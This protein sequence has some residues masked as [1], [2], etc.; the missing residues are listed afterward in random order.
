MAATMLPGLVVAVLLVGAVL[1]A[2]LPVRPRAVALLG[3]ATGVISGALLLW[4]A[5]SVWTGGPVAATWLDRLPLALPSAVSVRVDALSAIFLVLLAVVSAAVLLFAQGYLDGRPAGPTRR[6]YGLF[7]L[8]V[9]AMA[10]VVMAADWVLFLFA[11]EI[12]TLASYFLVIWDW[13]E[14]R[15]ARSAWVYL[16]TTHVASSG[17]LIAMCSLSVIAGDFSFAATAAALTG[18]FARL[19]AFAHLL[20][21]CFVLGF[22]TKA[23]VWPFSFWLPEAYRSAPMPATAVYSGLMAKMGIYGLVR[24]L[25]GMLPAGGQP[26]LIWGLIV[27]T[28][29]TAS[30]LV[31]NIRSLSEL[32]AKRLVAQSSIGQIG[33]IVLGVGMAAALSGR[34]PLLAAVAFAGA[35]YHLINHATFKPLLFLTVG[36]VEHYS[37][38]QDLK[39][40]GGL[41]GPL[42]LTAGLTLLGALA[43]AG[44]PPLNGFASKWLL[45]RA[46]VFGGI[47][48]PALAVYGVIA[49][50]ISTV[51]L[52]AYL[53][54][55]GTVFLG[56]E[57]EYPDGRREPESRAMAASLAILGA[58]CVALGLFP[59]PVVQ[60][61]LVALAGAPDAALF[62]A[63]AVTGA[64]V[65]GTALGGAGYQPLMVVLALLLCALLVWLIR[66]L[67]TQPVRLTEPWFGGEWLPASEARYGAEH[68]YKPFLAH[69]AALLRPWWQPTFHAPP[70]LEQAIDADR[71][72][73]RPIYSGYRALAGL[74]GRWHAGRVKG[75]VGWQLAATVL[76][77]VILIGVEGGLR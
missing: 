24:V 56:P 7:L 33:Y 43:I 39:R 73:L 75:Y 22:I 42:P 14:E 12:M 17:M 8:L 66:R 59:A 77:I 10:V 52:A 27:A 1:C 51:S 26:A 34:A 11:W 18:L 2:A 65:M 37:G 30:M 21:G 57:R 67:A 63:G 74:T 62:G 53:K 16:L 23:A 68:L 5:V 31:G 3:L 38:T 13:G 64:D 28:L 49:I 71:W 35:L 46:A 60:A 15:N 6:F 47:E 29:G 69:W 48:L 58:A 72:L 32:D 19:P 45:Y 40:L 76:L 50:F 9:G 70:A 61:A 44:T 4:L 54:Y 36:S 25:I 55:F 41:L 20:V